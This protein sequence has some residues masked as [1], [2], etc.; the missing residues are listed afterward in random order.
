MHALRREV[1]SNRAPIRRCTQIIDASL[2]T[3]TERGPQSHRTGTLVKSI[4]LCNV[5]RHNIA[6]ARFDASPRLLRRSQL[7]LRKDMTRN[8]RQNAVMADGDFIERISLEAALTWVDAAPRGAAI[9]EAPLSAAYGRVLAEPIA[10]PAD[11]PPF[12]LACL[13]GYALAADATLGA[14]VYNPLSL[15]LAPTAQSLTGLHAVAC[16]AGAPLPRG[17]DAVLPIDAAEVRSGILEVGEP[18]PRGAGAIKRGDIAR[19]GAIALPAGLRLGPAQI[20][21]AAS[22]GVKTAKVAR[23]PVTTLWIAGAKPPGV[24]A[25]AAAMSALIARDGGVARCSV[26]GLLDDDSD[27][28]IL[29]GRSGWGE[30]DDSV[31]RLQ[32]A[33]GRW[34]CHGV[35]F[36]PGGSTGLGWIG[37]KPVVLV[38][39][40]PY[41]ALAAYEVIVG[42]LVRRLAGRPAA[43]AGIARWCKLAAKIA[44]PVGVAEF[45]PVAIDGAVATPIAVAPFDGLLGLSRAAGFTLIPAGLEGFAEG[46]EIEVMALDAGEAR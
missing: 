42:R 1:A 11:R 46:V 24:E 3:T 40:D 7:S 9:E 20:A 14:S 39:G 33:G 2:T 5:L 4:S 36:S 21:L 29:V 15:P 31:V 26:G 12:D 44:S 23:R 38:P 17:A 37:G 6:E 43:F 28:L 8:E 30:D 35:A 27:A 41:S 10:F 25:L 19:S 22:A 13:D 32:A 34:D 16:C 18:A 45:V